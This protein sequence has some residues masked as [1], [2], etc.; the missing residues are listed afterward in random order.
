M[1]SKLVFVSIAG[2]IS[3][4]FF[5]PSGSSRAL[6]AE[7]ITYG[8]A[9][10]TYSMYYLPPL[11]AEEKGFWKEKGLDVEWVPFKAG[12]PLNQALVAGSINL[13]GQFAS[14]FLL[15]ASR[16]VPAIVVSTLSYGGELFAW[17]RGDSP[18]KKPQDMG[19]AKFAIGRFGGAEHAYSRAMAFG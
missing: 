4:G 18:I 1:R 7:K 8:T 15:A 16:G 2:I 11:A 12:T 5:S 17:V 9:V 19:S 13:G 6:A 14:S 3:F 10:G